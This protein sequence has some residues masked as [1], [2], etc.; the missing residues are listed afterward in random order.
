MIGWVVGW[1]GVLHVL[2]GSVNGV[3]EEGVSYIDRVRK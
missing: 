3:Y 2:M 1:I